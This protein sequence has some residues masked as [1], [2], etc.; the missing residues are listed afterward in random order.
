[1]IKYKLGNVLRFSD[2]LHFSDELRDLDLDESVN[3]SLGVGIKD[4]PSRIGGEG[5]GSL[6][7]PITGEP[8]ADDHESSV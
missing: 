5:D 2:E 1:M 7:V 8:L 3:N 4:P 6:P